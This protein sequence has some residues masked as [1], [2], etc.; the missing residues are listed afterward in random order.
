MEQKIDRTIFSQRYLDR[1]K[2][3]P[4]FVDLE[5]PTRTIHLL[6]PG[7]RSTFR[8]PSGTVEGSYRITG[9]WRNFAPGTYSLR[10]INLRLG[11]RGKSEAGTHPN[12]PQYRGTIHEFYIRHSR[13]GTIFS[14]DFDGPDNRTFAGDPL[15]PVLAVGQ[16]TLFYAWRLR[17]G[18]GTGVTLTQNIEGVL[19]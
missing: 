6:G 14:T 15:R 16:G 10:L 3:P 7:R 8:A 13:D 4:E 17:E 11:V 1:R 18:A 5:L 2:D 19:G 12:A 9:S